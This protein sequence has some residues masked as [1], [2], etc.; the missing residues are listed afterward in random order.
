[1]PA[2]FAA[3]GSFHVKSASTYFVMVLTTVRVLPFLLTVT[4][5]RSNTFWVSTFGVRWYS[6]QRYSSIQISGTRHSSGVSTDLAA[7]LVSLCTGSAVLRDASSTG[8]V[9]VGC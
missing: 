3:V 1:M 9:A 4:L 2:L 7:E 5:I 8:G 6:D